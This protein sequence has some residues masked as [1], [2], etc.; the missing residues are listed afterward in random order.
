MGPGRVKMTDKLNPI[1]PTDD[2]ARAL[3]RALLHSSA[4]AVL[5]FTDPG[6]GGVAVSRIG[7]GLAPDGGAISLLSDISLHSQALRLDP[8]CAL[9]VG[10]PGPRGDPLNSPRLS[11]QAT[12]R[13]ADGDRPALRQAWLSQH[14]KARLYIDFADFRFV[15]FDILGA[16]L[17]GGF[18]RAYHL[19]AED[20][21]P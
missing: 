14:P 10:E 11:L 3:A 1:R 15:R 16:A 18:G 19:S 5:A 13:F 17:N 12:A 20:I 6:N 2:D 8:R 4:T 7:F 9:L 21:A